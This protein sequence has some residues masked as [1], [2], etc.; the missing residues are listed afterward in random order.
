MTPGDFRILKINQM[1]TAQIQR[2]HIFSREAG[3]RIACGIG[4]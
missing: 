4:V 3:F 1:S 2:E